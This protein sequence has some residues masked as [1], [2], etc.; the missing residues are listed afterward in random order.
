MKA[1]VRYFDYDLNDMVVKKCENF[2]YTANQE[3]EFMPVDEPAKIYKSIVIKHPKVSI[4]YRS[5]LEKMEVTVEGFQYTKNG[6]ILTTT[7][8]TIK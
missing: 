2:H 7:T 3:F 5:E 6:Y 8:I 4:H 1:T